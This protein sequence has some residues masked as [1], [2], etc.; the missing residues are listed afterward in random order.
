[1]IQPDTTKLSPNVRNGTPNGRIV[2]I[3]ATRSGTSM[4]PSEFA[5]TLN[6]FANRASGVSTHWVVGRDGRTAR[7]APDNKIAQHA[8]QHNT[9]AWGIELEQGIEND[10]FTAEQMAA[11]VT[12]CRGYMEDYKVEPR[13]TLDMRQSGFIGH[14]ETPQGRSVG[15][16]DPGRLFNWNAFIDLLTMEEGIPIMPTVWATLKN[17]PGNVAFRTYILT[18]DVRGLAS[19]YVRNPAEHNALKESDAAGELKQVSIE[20]LHAFHCVPDPLA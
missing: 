7:C 1:M 16:S 14:D 6:W 18:A 8:G 3:H 13:H 17:R 20:T 2:I 5:G 12:V 15:K 9:A 10:G 11:L 4:N 19:Y